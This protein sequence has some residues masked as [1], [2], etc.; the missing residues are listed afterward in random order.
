MAAAWLWL[1]SRLTSSSS[2]NSARYSW[3]PKDLIAAV[4]GSSTRRT[5]R[6]GRPT[7]STKFSSSSWE[8]GTVKVLGGVEPAGALTTRT[9]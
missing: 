4:S 2:W 9:R 5:T 3:L 6:R 1:R 7:R 8:K